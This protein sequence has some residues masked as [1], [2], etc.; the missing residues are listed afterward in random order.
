MFQLDLSFYKVQGEIEDLKVLTFVERTAS[1]SGAVIVLDLPVNPVALKAL[2]QLI[3]V[4]GFTKSVIRCDGHWSSQSS[5]EQVGREM[6]LLTQVSPQY[7]HQ[8][9]GTV[10]TF[11]KTLYDQVRAIRIGLA[12]QLGTHSDQ[13]E[14]SLLPCLFN[15]QLIRSPIVHFGERVLAHM[16]SQPPSHELQIRS[17]PQKSFSLWFGKDVITCMHIVSDGQ[18]LKTRTIAL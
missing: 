15:T 6:S 17:S 10:E 1:T 5:L 4:N 13:V 14:G 3:A 18:V 7:S 16:Q 12:D 8:G 9:Q 2:K 11:R